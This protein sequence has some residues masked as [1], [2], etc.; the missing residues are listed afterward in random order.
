[1]IN[2]ENRKLVAKGFFNAYKE[3]NL[4]A[5]VAFA[6]KE[7]TFRYVPLGDDG[8][9]KIDAT[10]GPTWKGIANALISAFPD[11]SNEVKSITVD[12]EGNAI[13][14]VFIAGTQQNDILGIPSKGKH[15]N[16]EHLFILQIDDDY[17]ITDIT[18][19]WDNW[20]WFQQI[21]FNPANS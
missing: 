18:C 2:V 16:T 8:I 5:A 11:L 3:H 1:M 4:D 13:V 10:E 7:S 14:R 12:D 19:F 6:S 15:Y 21:G 9:G 20:N 17:K